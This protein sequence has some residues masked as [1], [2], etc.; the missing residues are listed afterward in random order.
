MR[1]IFRKLEVCGLDLAALTL[2]KGPHLLLLLL[3]LLVL[4]L[5]VGLFLRR[6]V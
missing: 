2:F 3:L 1:S 6:P 5:L 4:L